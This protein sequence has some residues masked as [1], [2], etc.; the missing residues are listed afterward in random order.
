[1]GLDELM[2]KI[3][4]QIGR[5]HQDKHLR[6]ESAD[7]QIAE[8]RLLVISECDKHDDCNGITYEIISTN[9]P[10]G[11]KTGTAYWAETTD[12]KHFVILG[13]ESE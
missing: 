5:E 3:G 8:I 10:D 7:G 2:N 12:V 11:W 6:I 9:R 4:L 1:L 13:D